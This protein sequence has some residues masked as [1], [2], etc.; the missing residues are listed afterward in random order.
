MPGRAITECGT[1][2]TG[3]NIVTPLTV[4]H[5]P[6]GRAAAPRRWIVKFVDANLMLGWLAT[7]VPVKT[8]VLMLRHPCAVIG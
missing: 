5:L 1:W 6:L 3:A 7:R 2:N 4:S 8:P